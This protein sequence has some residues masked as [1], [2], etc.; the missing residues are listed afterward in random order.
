MKSLPLLLVCNLSVIFMA[1][2]KK[3][4][5]TLL[6]EEAIKSGRVVKT[7]K[8]IDPK[9]KLQLLKNYGFVVREGTS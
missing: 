9:I 1:R 3:D 7:G 4:I 2:K 8:D 6:R 5:T